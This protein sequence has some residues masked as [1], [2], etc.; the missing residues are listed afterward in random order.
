[1]IL[2]KFFSR[3]ALLALAVL[4]VVGF[5]ST[6]SFARDPANSAAPV[7]QQQAVRS[8]TFAISSP[9]FSNAGKIPAKF[10]CSGADVSPELTWTAPPTGTLSFAL[11]ADDPDAPVG[12]W[13]HWVVFDLPANT[14]TLPENVPK[15]DEVP[16][17][18][19]QGRNDFR[20]IGYGGP[21]PPPGEL[22]RYF[23]KLYALAKMLNLKPG[24]RKQD[25]ERVMQGHILAQAELMGRYQR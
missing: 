16:G 18:G 15:V 7:D 6:Q 24:A 1:M 4:P 23:F 11:I 12:T 25:V 13:V 22:H 8:M 19:S 3:N 5:L 10:T 2:T 21:C 17:G 20:K 9:S 14:T